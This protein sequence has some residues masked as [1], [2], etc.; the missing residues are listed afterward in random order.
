[1]AGLLSTLRLFRWF[2][3]PPT[4]LQ[5]VRVPPLLTR[6]HDRRGVRRFF[7]LWIGWSASIKPL[8]REI[9]W[10][11]VVRYPAFSL[12][13]AVRPFEES[14]PSVSCTCH[15]ASVASGG[16][17]SCLAGPTPETQAAPGTRGLLSSCGRSSASGRF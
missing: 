5:D 14:G 1:M 16:V 15:L 11:E 9:S 6:K 10:L 13:T 8:I 7:L 4:P 17:S 12:A 2:S 3:A